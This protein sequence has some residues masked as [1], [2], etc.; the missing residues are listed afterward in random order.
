ML[1]MKLTDAVE[2]I[3]QTDGVGIPHGSATISREAVAVQVDDVDIHCAQ[4]KAFLKYAGAFVHESIDT[5]IHDFF[6][7]DLTLANAG[8]RCPFT[9]QMSDLRIRNGAPV[10]VVF[11]PPRAGFLAVASHLTQAVS[12]KGVTN[13]GFFKMT[14]FLADSPADIQACEVSDGKRT[15]GHAEIVKRGINSFDGGTLF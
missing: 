10:F 12:G 5:A 1:F 15:H 9:D 4:R 7:G 13:A 14:I 6:P 11:I 3:L 8:F 2:D